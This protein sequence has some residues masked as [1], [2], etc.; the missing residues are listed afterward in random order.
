MSEPDLSAALQQQVLNALQNETPLNIR[1]G[2]S[3]TFLGNA[4]RTTALP[5][6]V[7][8]HRGIVEYDPRELVLTARSGTPLMQIESVLAGAGQMLAFEPP[9]FG[10][11]A[12][13]GG[14]IACALSGPRRP[15]SGSARDFVLGCKLLN[16][17]GDILRFGGQ[18]MKNV[19]GYDVSRLMVGAYGTLGIL[20]DI[21]L[22]VLP[23]PA[24]SIT[25][26]REC[27]AAEAIESMS[28]L[29]G[30]PYP[31]DGTCYDGDQCHVRISGSV[32]AVG[33]A[34]TKI[35]GE[36]MPD[37]DAFWT[38]LRE[39]ELPFFRHSGALYRIMVKPATLP[40]SI[41]GSYLLDWGG[42]QR[43]LYS[44]EDVATIRRQVRLAGGHVTVFRSGEHVAEIFQP[45]PAP[46]LAIHQRLKAGF[47]PKNIFNRGRIYASL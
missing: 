35:P 8:M 37:A 14:T 9:H 11:S 46:L 17:H 45:L 38:A 23:R 31:V 39:H 41:E 6:D 19:A 25:V 32:Q 30:K 27:S 33:E 47:D 15:Y 22:K 12:T 20:L 16:G 21:S 34:R 4:S 42:A 43:W 5:I 44:H 36:E 13:L 2:G 28:A 26:T 7:S 1:G 3:K 24:A 29:L 10:S 18:V 40:L